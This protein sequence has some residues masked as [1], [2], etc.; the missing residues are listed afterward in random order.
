MQAQWDTLFVRILDPKTGQLLREHVRQK[1]G[2]YRIRNEDRLLRS[3]L[4]VIQLL[5]RCERAAANIGVLCHRIYNQLGQ[6]GVGVRR[7]QG[8]LSLAKRYGLA[9]T[10]DACRVGLDMESTNTGSC[11]VFASSSNIAISST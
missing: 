2:W 8:V 11:V 9:A 10:E 3:P 5:S 6:M 1:R 7:I 4:P